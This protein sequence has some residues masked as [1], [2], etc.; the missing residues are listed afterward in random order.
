MSRVPIGVA[1]CVE[2]V[3]GIT[4]TSAE[5]RHAWASIAADWADEGEIDSHEAGPIAA[6]LAWVTLLETDKFRIRASFLDSLDSLAAKDLV[7]EIILK[8]VT[9]GL[10]RQDLDT[11]EIEFYDTLTTKLEEKLGPSTQD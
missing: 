2:L 3:R 4:S 11:A 5:E 10:S 9:S 1:R 6:V 8:Q 7:P